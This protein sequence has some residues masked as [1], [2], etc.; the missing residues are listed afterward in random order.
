MKFVITERAVVT[1]GVDIPA[2]RTEVMLLQEVVMH[3]P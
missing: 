3:A 1:N 2:Q